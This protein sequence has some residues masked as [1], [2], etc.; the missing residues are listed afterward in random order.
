MRALHGGRR[1]F[2]HTGVDGGGGVELD[3]LLVGAELQAN[4][5]VFLVGDGVEGGDVGGGDRLIEL[6]EVGGE[7]D[8]VEGALVEGGA[9]GRVGD[10]GEV[11]L[12]AE[13]GEAA[14]DC[15]VAEVD[16]VD[17]DSGALSV[18]AGVGDVGA[19]LIEW[20]N[21]AV[22]EVDA[23][24]DHEDEAGV[25]F[26][27]R[28]AG[29]GGLVGA[30]GFGAA[31]PLLDEGGQG[32]VR[33]AVGSGD[34]HGEADLGSGSGVVGGEAL[35]GDDAAILHV[36]DE[37]LGAGTELQDPLLDVLKLDAEGGAEAVVD[38]DGNLDVGG[39]D[40]GELGDGGG[41]AVDLGGDV[42]GSGSEGGF[43]V[44]ADENL[45]GDGALFLGVGGEGSAGDE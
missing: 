35:L 44:D 45:G 15:A 37:D 27:G 14:T 30:G 17:G 29:G 3:A 34:A 7:A 12:A 18:I 42:G 41:L 23:V 40:R 1:G 2:L 6:L 33:A 13:A 10:L 16:G 22:V 9:T 38:E 5:G 20:G 43:G 4:E 32:E 11:A 21:A 39:E 28:W 31:G 36:A 24:G 26:G 25:A 8:G 19:V